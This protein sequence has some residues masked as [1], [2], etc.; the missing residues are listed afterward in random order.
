MFN[1]QEMED[2]ERPTRETPTSSPRPQQPTQRTVNQILKGSRLTGD[3]HID[4]D[5]E[6]S[7]DVEGNITSDTGSNVV[8]KGTCKGGI[9][10]KEGSVKIE[11]ELKDG[12]IIAGSDVTITGRF[13]GG[14]VT[15]KGKILIDGEFNGILEANEIELGPRAKGAGR[16]LYRD[17]LSIAKGARVE[18]EIACDA[19]D[20]AVKLEE[21][22][23]QPERKDPKPAD[24]Q[25]SLTDAAN[26]S[27]QKVVAMKSSSGDDQSA[28]PSPSTAK[29]SQSAG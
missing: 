29:A 5:L 28:K 13:G 27:D 10:T 26:K 2:Q 19:R 25:R 3:V 11:G 20:K 4:C 22:S 12:D 8:I 16:L 15:A 6:L 18:G 7:G 1:K 9:R 14:K 17:S 24:S 21:K 23:A